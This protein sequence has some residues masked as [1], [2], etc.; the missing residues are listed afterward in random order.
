MRLLLLLSVSIP[1]S[2]FSSRSQQSDLGNLF[3]PGEQKTQVEIN[4]VGCCDWSISMPNFCCIETRLCC[5][6]LV[7]RVGAHAREEHWRNVVR[8]VGLLKLNV[9]PM[10]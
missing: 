9:I 3:S 8:K 4:L 5:Y 1:H 7:A 10:G 2:K 6:K